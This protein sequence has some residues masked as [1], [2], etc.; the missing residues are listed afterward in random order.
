AELDEKPFSLRELFGEEQILN[1][2]MALDAV[3]FDLSASPQKMLPERHFTMGLF[4]TAR[5]RTLPFMTRCAAEFFR[6][7]SRQQHLPTRVGLVG[8]GLIFKPTAI[9][10]HMT[11]LTTVNTRQRRVKVAAVELI[12]HDL[13]DCGNLGN[14]KA[15]ER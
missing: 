7:M 12:E 6:R 1:I 15:I 9:D 5:S 10:P 13:L 2:S 8:I 4:H 3:R 11:G 14:G